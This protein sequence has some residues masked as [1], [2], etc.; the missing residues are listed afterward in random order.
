MHVAAYIEQL[1]RARSAPTAKL[2]L[3]ALRHLFDWMVIGQIMPTNQAPA[4][5]GPR[6]IVRRGK[7]PVLDP[8]DARQL[9]DAIDTTTII[10]LRD[11]ALIGPMVYSF[12]RIGAAFWR[13]SQLKSHA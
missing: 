1:S 12:A 2:R 6:H 8:A 9:L 13:Q 11:R 3:A 7:T 5:R 4:V 10:S